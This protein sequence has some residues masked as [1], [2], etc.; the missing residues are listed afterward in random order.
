MDGYVIHYIVNLSSG[1]CRN[2]DKGLGLVQ[3]ALFFK[4]PWFDCA[5]QAVLHGNSDISGEVSQR[6]SLKISLRLLCFE[7]SSMKDG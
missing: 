3:I 6:N 2:R 7:F 1:F 5:K 4:L